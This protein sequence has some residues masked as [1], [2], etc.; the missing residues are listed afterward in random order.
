MKLIWRSTVPI[1]G[2]HAFH[3]VTDA[4][5][6]SMSQELRGDINS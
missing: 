5:R 6:K 2:V 4:S 3:D 1:G